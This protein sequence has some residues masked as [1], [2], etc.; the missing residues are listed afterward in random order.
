M[1][2]YRFRVWLLP[3]PPLAFEPDSEVWRDVTVDGSHTL[4]ALHKGIFEAFDR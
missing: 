3:N 4:A 2:I 1:S